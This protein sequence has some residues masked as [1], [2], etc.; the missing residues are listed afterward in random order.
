MTRRRSAVGLAPADDTAGAVAINAD[1][2]AAAFERGDGRAVA[3]QALGA[4]AESR[5]PQAEDVGGVEFHG[6]LE[7][8]TNAL[9]FAHGEQAHQLAQ[10][11]R[12]VEQAE[13]LLAIGLG[14]P[15]GP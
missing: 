10:D 5:P 9:A 6:M 15:R 12:G 7:D 1:V 2:S 4:L 8:A 14:L 13:F 11:Q 3:A